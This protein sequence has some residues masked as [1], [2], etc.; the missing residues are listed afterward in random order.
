V[1][2]VAE[3]GRGPEQMLLW[4]RLL[5]GSKHRHRIELLARRGQSEQL[6]QP[7]RHLIPD[8]VNVTQRRKRR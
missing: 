5:T 4:Q 1:R 2:E 6:R 3:Q 7:R 8:A